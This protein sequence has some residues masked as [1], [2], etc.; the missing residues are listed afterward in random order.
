MTNVKLTNGKLFVKG[1]MSDVFEV[2]TKDVRIDMFINI[3]LIPNEYTKEN[4][5]QE[6]SFSVDLLNETITDVLK[7]NGYTI[8]ES[9][10]IEWIQNQDF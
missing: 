8:I 9:N 6:E 5:V 4:G 3:E 7:E 1:E 2:V 10:Q